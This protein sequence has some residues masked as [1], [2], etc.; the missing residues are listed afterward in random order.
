METLHGLQLLFFTI[1]PALQESFLDNKLN[2]VPKDLYAKI[3]PCGAHATCALRQTCRFWR[4]TLDHDTTRKIINEWTNYDTSESFR[5]AFIVWTEKR[6]LREPSF[7][8]RIF[9]SSTNVETYAMIDLFL[10]SKE[11]PNDVRFKEQSYG[12]LHAMVFGGF[13]KRARYLL[14]LGIDIEQK[15]SEGNTP[16]HSAG[17]ALKDAMFVLLWEHGASGTVKNK[18]GKDPYDLTVEHGRDHWHPENCHYC[19]EYG[20][21]YRRILDCGK[22]R[23]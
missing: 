8:Q 19:I 18:K 16:L 9:D 20:P 17:K 6:M 23:S 3:I 4:D 13:I 11:N 5:K 21:R 2:F 14:A 15:D 7:G 12:L 1:Y 10:L 22:K